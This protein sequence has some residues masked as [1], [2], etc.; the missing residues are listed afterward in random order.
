MTSTKELAFGVEVYTKRLERLRQRMAEGGCSTVLYFSPEN[1]F[2]L[3]GYNTTGHY[4]GYQCLVVSL[5]RD[6]FMVVRRVEESNVVGRSWIERR[7]VYND[8]EDPVVTTV[9]A[10][11]GERLLGGVIG[12]NARTRA[13]SPA[14]Y[15]RLV[16]A[17][18]ESRIVDGFGFVERLRMI[19][20]PEELACI[21]EAC[22]I[23]E[24]GMRA[25]VAAMQCGATEEAIAA[26]VYRALILAGG[27][28]PGMPPF[29]ASGYRS[30]LAHATWE[31]GRRIAKGDVVLLEI[32]GVVKRYH[33]V[34]ARSLVVGQPNSAQKRYLDVVRA[35]RQAGVESI[36][37][38]VTAADVDRACK[39]VAAEAGLADHYLHRAGYGLGIA[40]PP[41][42][43]EGEI[44]SLRQGEE[45]V[46]EVNMVFHL[47][48]ALYFVQECCIALTETV[49]VSER[50][51][52]IMTEFPLDQTVA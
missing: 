22:G 13:L 44:V 50:G 32:P 12:M 23:A 35:I 26:E 15:M 19:K 10:L 2:Y 29:I 25:G 37:P 33:A 17:C 16:E 11:R 3:T 6:P 39:A 51:C 7:Y 43:D 24:A 20:D 5:E 27:E 40:Y 34:F 48:S 4:Y 46:L 52:E 41:K 28:Y 21:R 45:T 36:R 49:R 9:S 42:W 8:H 14:N 18:R 31:G 47:V 30:G 38:G 1:I